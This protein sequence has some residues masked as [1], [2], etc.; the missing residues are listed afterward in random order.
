MPSNTT[1]TGAAGNL[2]TL[3]LAANGSYTY[4]VAN[5]AAQFLAGRQWGH[6]H[7]CRHL[8]GHAC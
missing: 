8:H 2:G 6:Q 3:V 4:T 7:P 1:V 5:A